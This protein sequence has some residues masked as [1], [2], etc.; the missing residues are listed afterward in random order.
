VLAFWSGALIRSALGG[1]LKSKA[2]GWATAA[3][4]AQQAAGAAVRGFDLAPIVVLLLPVIG[5]QVQPSRSWAMRGE[6]FCPG[7]MLARRCLIEGNMPR[8]SARPLHHAARSEMIQRWE[9]EAL[10]PVR[11]AWRPRR[12]MRLVVHERNIK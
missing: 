3:A 10:S 6:I 7:P 9:S 8:R 5:M 1:W 2:G 11:R 4:T 12:G